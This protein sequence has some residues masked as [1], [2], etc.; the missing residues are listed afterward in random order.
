MAYRKAAPA[1]TLA[2]PPPS[3][4][5][6]IITRAAVGMLIATAALAVPVIGPLLLGLLG[7]PVA[8]ADARRARL[9]RK[10]YAHARSAHL[11]NPA[12][13]TAVGHV[14]VTDLHKVI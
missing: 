11:A 4:T 5:A 13:G 10:N 6:H 8:A 12:K 3:A 14:E 9:R 1:R 2:T 7:V